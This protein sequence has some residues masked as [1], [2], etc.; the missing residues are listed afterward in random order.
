MGKIAIY[1]QSGYAKQ[2]YSNEN[3][4]VRAFPGI[5]MIAHVLRKSEYEV[6][7]CS[8]STVQDY[9]IILISITSAC[10]WWSFIAERMTWRQG[11]YTVIIGG[12]GVLNVRL[13]LQY[14]D[15]FSCRCN[16]KR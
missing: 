14:A 13:F 11:D 12:A 10:D 2:T 16:I 9:K 3:Y 8:A 15:I 7:Y 1:V 6:E 5:E 4:N